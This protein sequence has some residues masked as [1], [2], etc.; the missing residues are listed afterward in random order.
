MS[1]GQRPVDVSVAAAIT[2][3]CSS[4][5]HEDQPIKAGVAVHLEVAGHN[6]QASPAIEGAVTID[7]GEGGRGHAAGITAEGS[8]VASLRDRVCLLVCDKSAR[9]IRRAQERRQSTDAERGR[10]W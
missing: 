9:G 8:E 10:L 1:A 5:K 6:Q 3:D 4:A 2:I 7:K